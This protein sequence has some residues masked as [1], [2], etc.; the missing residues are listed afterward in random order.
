MIY[1]DFSNN[2]ISVVVQDQ[3]PEFVRNNYATFVAFMEA[4]YEYLE[5]NGKL[6]NTLK[7]IP[8]FLDV[9]YVVENN[10]TDFIELFREMYLS[11]I[12]TTVLAD[13]AK[14]LKHIKTF[15]SSRGTTKSFKFL[16]RVLY[17]QDVATFNT[18]S[19]ILK[20]SDGKWYQPSILRIIPFNPT[21]VVVGIPLSEFILG[22]S[23]MG[24]TVIGSIPPI[25]DWVGKEII[26]ESSFAT[27]VVESA[28]ISTIPN[29]T[30]FELTIS[31]ATKGF[32][33]SEVVTA[34]TGIETLFGTILGI[35]PG[36][37][38][39]NSGSKYNVGDLAIITGGGGS[40]AAAIISSVSSGQLVDL[41]VTYGGS[42]YQVYPNWLVSVAGG[43]GGGAN[44]VIFNVD[45]SGV[46]TPNQFQIIDTIPNSF[47]IPNA[48]ITV[49][50]TV[51]VVNYGN[52]GPITI[53][54]IVS[55]GQGYISAPT[56][57]VSEQ[58]LIGNSQTSLA[59]L[60]AI[61]RFSILNGGVNYSINDDI[62]VYNTTSR[63]TRGAGVVTSVDVNGSITGTIVTIP[64]ISGYANV[65]SGANLVTGFGGSLFTKELIANNNITTPNSGT[66]I[67]INGES[68]KVTNIVSDTSLTV[69]GNYASNANN[70]VVRLGGYMVG[71]YGY[72]PS[73]FPSGFYTT[74]R[75][76]G[77]GTGATILPEGILGT[78]A[79][80]GSVGSVYGI[81]E[82]ISMTNFGDHYVSQPSIDL[83]H[84]GDGTATA[85]AQVIS[86]S[87]KYPG[88]F[89]NEDGMLSAR[90]YLEDPYTYNNYSYKIFSSALVTAYHDL[91]YQIL[92]PAGANM[93]GVTQIFRGTGHSDISSN[94]GI[95]IQ[96][97]TTI[98]DVNFIL[99]TSLLS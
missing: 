50:S 13:K 69:A 8:N 76:I 97:A 36:I 92:N 40:N 89:L 11:S 17:N 26:G 86:S 15:Y 39:T 63:G 35:V 88:Y 5:Q 66:W 10:L 78:D 44:A 96:T 41:S 57:N 20:A 25:S 31:N 95:F 1:K 83:T 18:G 53:A 23:E 38:V 75:S 2:K 70:Q 27:A 54:H 3:L 30:Y 43:G 85:I 74:I 72:T 6:T 34:N 42:G 58:I 37:T 46:L 99:N 93:I 24:A 7:N 90:R 98:I 52:C 82:T 62:I 73:D 64:S 84:S 19:Q 68:H 33:P 61:G 59:A 94:T 14:L 28:T 45:T 56:I 81:I 48:N 16:F 51:S 77:G 80:L 22:T 49:S 4:Y 79:V 67:V 91:V 29:L 21:N 47:A 55:G 87:F 65:T 32:L 71:G 12:P 9:D 60:G